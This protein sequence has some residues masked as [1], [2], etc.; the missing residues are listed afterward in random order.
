MYRLVL[1]DLDETLIVNQHVPVFNQEAVK[2]VQA[3]GVKFCVATGRSFNMI[4]DILKEVN[5]YNKEN[6]YSVCFNGGLIMENKDFR[7]LHFKGLDYDLALSLFEEG[8]KRS[9]CML[10][11]TLDCCY[12][13]NPDPNEVQRKKDQHAPFKIVDECDM[14]FLKNEKI[15]KML[16]MRRDMDFLKALREEIA[17][18][19]E[20]KVT[21]SFSSN[22]YLECNAYGVNKG[23]GLRWLAS[24]LNIPV[25]ETIAIGDNY[26]DVPMIKEAGL[27]ACVSS[28]A[29]DIKAQSDY[30]CKHDYGDG[31]VKE[32]LDQFI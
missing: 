19:L 24:Y 29:D 16:M 6:E 32:V 1:S 31:A 21:L 30:V 3:Q 7:I 4:D 14:S 26:N 9:L 27:G 25:S 20:G 12:I 18:R 23:Y 28:A 15:A 13:F 11:F 8:K 22:R 5:T 2:R 17:P 10:V